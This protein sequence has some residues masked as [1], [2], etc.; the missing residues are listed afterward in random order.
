M[1]FDTHNISIRNRLEIAPR[2]LL[3]AV[4]VMLTVIIVSFMIMQFKS[5]GEMAGISSDMMNRRT[6]DIRNSDYL[7]YDGK[8][9]SGADVVNFCRRVLNDCT[10]GVESEFRLVLKGSSGSIRIYRTYETA[11]SLWDT[12]GSEYVNPISHWKCS[13]IKNK[14]GIITEINFNK[15]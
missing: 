10:G 6:D 7:Q 11:K 1:Q 13:V 4:S 3:L 2:A 9:V 12:D 5:A 15:E 8:K 14:N